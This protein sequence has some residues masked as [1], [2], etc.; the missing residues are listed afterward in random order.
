VGTVADRVKETTVTK[1]TGTLTLDG[2]VSTFQ[3]FV[4]GVAAIAGTPSP[5]VW[6]GVNYLIVHSDALGNNIDIEIGTGTLTAGGTA[7]DTLTRGTVV[8]SSNSNALV[9]FGSGT[10]TV[11]CAP[12]AGDLGA[13]IE[14][15][16]FYESTSGSL[17]TGSQNWSKTISSVDVA[18]SIVIPIMRSMESYQQDDGSGECSINAMELSSATNVETY[19]TN[20]TTGVYTVSFAVMQFKSGFLETDVQIGRSTLQVTAS[21]WETDDIT[22]S[23]VTTY[24]NAFVIMSSGGTYREPSSGDRCQGV[25]GALTSAT[26]IQFDIIGDGTTSSWTNVGWQVVEPKSKFIQA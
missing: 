10:K 4:T 5:Q 14:S 13:G 24:A 7:K 19:I 26:N 2:T 21:D 15:I 6:T 8:F 25:R 23:A 17:G 20:Q 22:I 16:K 1:G 3:T 12:Q 11:V 18:R 9:D